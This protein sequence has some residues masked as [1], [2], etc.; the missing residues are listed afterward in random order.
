MLIA[1]VLGKAK[2]S[3]NK[4]IVTSTFFLDLRQLKLIKNTL[5]FCFTSQNR[6]AIILSVY[7]G[8][9]P[10]SIWNNTSRGTKER[11]YRRSE[12]ES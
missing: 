11:S 1:N 8:A 2:E 4:N 7:R 6:C 10:M 9:I 12:V 5:L 3:Y